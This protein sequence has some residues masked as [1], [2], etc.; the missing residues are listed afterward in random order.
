M[1]ASPTMIPWF[2][3]QAYYLK[4]HLHDKVDDIYWNR[5]GK[6]KNSASVLQKVNQL[7]HFTLQPLIRNKIW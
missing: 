2:Q 6:K 3:N 4:S 7:L 1:F 5:V